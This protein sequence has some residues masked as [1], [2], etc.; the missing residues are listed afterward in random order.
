LKHLHIDCFVGISGDMTLAALIDLGV[1]PVAL[2]EALSGLR[3]HIGI[4]PQRV[5]RSGIEGTGVVV[6]ADDDAHSDHAPH[7]FHDHEHGHHD[8]SHDHGHHHPND[9]PHEPAH[10]HHHGLSYSDCRAAI[11]D[12]GL[13][14]LATERSLA[15][16]R[17]VGEAEASVHGADLEAVHFHEL[18]GVDTL[19]DICG[20]AV[21]L[22]ML[23]V[24]SVSAGPIPLAHGWVQCAHGTMPVPPPAV[25]KLVEG[26][27]TVAVD[28]SG[29]TVTPT[30]AAIIKGLAQSIG[31]MPAMRVERVG[32]G[33][34][35]KDFDPYPNLLRLFI[36]E[37]DALGSLPRVT[38]VCTQVDDCTPEVLAYA[39]QR[40]MD[41]GALD[42]YL[43]P[44][45]MKKGRPGTSVTVIA[46][47]SRA[48]ELAL[49]LMAETS[50]IGVRVH[51][52]SRFCLSRE[53]S[54]VSTPFGPLRVKLILLPDGSHR[55]TP[56]YE[57]CAQ[58][59][60]E[61]G[62]PLRE[63]YEAALAAARDA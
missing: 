60:A 12:A 50:T 51:E 21:G 44:V 9:H 31:P 47:P 34:G 41:A 43:S 6:T 37:V 32:Y 52:C 40:L 4:A 58:I 53:A 48:H 7:G 28:I 23:G 10:H 46:P 35:S 42:V 27:P 1:D 18:G 3:H 39:A 8:H 24:E 15:I 5:V 45:T 16:L 19:I 63:V 57:D 29:E 13:S 30:G 20:V 33:A 38:E 26:L 55:V 14:D 11:L 62:V 61:R 59:A 17:C 2:V 56:E 54:T 49:I 22:E 36:G 25:A